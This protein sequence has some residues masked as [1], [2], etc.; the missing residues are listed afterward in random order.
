[1]NFNK[2]SLREMMGNDVPQMNEPVKCTKR[3][4]N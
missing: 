4:S 2:T 3:T 1:M